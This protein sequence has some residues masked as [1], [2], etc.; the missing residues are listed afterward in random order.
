MAIIVH[1]FFYYAH[2]QVLFIFAHNVAQGPCSCARDR[3]KTRNIW[4]EFMK[5]D[6]KTSLL[7]DVRHASISNQKFVKIKLEL[8]QHSKAIKFQAAKRYYRTMPKTVY[9]P[10]LLCNQTIRISS[11]RN[12]Y[13]CVMKCRLLL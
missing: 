11:F 9:F 3:K 4:F 10:L 12:I 1:I 2:R 8:D 5:C 13:D 7:F 6:S